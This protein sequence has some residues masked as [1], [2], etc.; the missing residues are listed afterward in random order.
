MVSTDDSPSPTASDSTA[1]VVAVASDD[2]HRFSKPLQEEIT[3]IAGHGVAGDAHAGPTMIR[4]VRYRPTETLPNLR[5]VHLVH[6]EL[7]DEVAVDGFTVAP[8]QLG[9]NVTTRGVDLLSLPRG[10]RIRLGTD[11]EVEITGLRNP[12]KQ[13]NGFQ[14]GLMKRL[15]SRGADG[16]VTRLAGVMAIVLSDGVVRAGDPLSITLPEG[17]HEALQPV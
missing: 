11:A 8:G 7:F 9:E 14:S 13:I 12:C 15:V 2:V 6:H 16:Q 5:Q 10:T 3:L 4:R 1:T 17:E